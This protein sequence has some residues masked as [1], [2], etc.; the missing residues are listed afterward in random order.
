M[1]RPS[2]RRYCRHPAPAKGSKFV[3]RVSVEERGSLVVSTFTPLP[4]CC[5]EKNGVGTVTG[6]RQETAPSH[7]LDASGDWFPF[8]RCRRS[9]PCRWWLLKRMVLLIS[10]SSWPVCG[11]QLTRKKLANEKRHKPWLW[12]PS[13]DDDRLSRFAGYCCTV[14]GSGCFLSALPGRESGREDSG[15]FFFYKL[16]L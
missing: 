3:K 2:W 6:L 9:T 16:W 1:H 11:L 14:W 5:W 13:F 8:W 10:L 4:H 12:I 7:R 15:W